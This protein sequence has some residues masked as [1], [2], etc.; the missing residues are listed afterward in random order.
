MTR[1][2][3][4]ELM[5]VATATLATLALSPALPRTLAMGEVALTASALLLAQGLVRDLFIKFGRRPAGEACTVG[6]GVASQSNCMCMESSLGMVGIIA[7]VVL[8]LTV[9]PRNVH[10]HWS[11]WP[12]LVAGVGLAGFFMK[13][14]VIDWKSRRLRRVADHRQ[15]KFGRRA[16]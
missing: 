4:I 11:F 12:A 8:L 5:A 6:N 9:V 15:V 2:D 3:K 7:G 16:G 14:I 1:A 13:S 10:L